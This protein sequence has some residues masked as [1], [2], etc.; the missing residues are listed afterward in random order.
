MKDLIIC[1]LV[2]VIFVLSKPLMVFVDHKGL[3]VLITMG[4]NIGLV[5]ISVHQTKLIFSEKSHQ[6]IRL[7]IVVLSIIGITI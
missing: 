5:V 2:L 6:F 3:E 4:A 7:S 1:F